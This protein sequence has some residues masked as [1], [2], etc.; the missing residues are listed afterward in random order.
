VIEVCLIVIGRESRV[1]LGSWTLWASE[2]P[3]NLAAYAGVLD[4]SWVCGFGRS[5]VQCLGS[6]WTERFGGNSL[7]G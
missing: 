2:N 4:T 1:W 5:V 7:R 3:V 6:Q